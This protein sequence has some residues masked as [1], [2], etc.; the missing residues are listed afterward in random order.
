[1]L[2]RVLTESHPQGQR[3]LSESVWGRSSVQSIQSGCIICYLDS[4]SKVHWLTDWLKQDGRRHRSECDVKVSRGKMIINVFINC[5]T[6]VKIKQFI[7]LFSSGLFQMLSDWMDRTLTVKR[8]VNV[9]TALQALFHNV[10]W[11]EKALS[12]CT[13]SREDVVTQF[14]HY[15][16]RLHGLELLLGPLL[17]TWTGQW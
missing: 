14:D 11:R 6:W 10:S 5:L 15:D 3:S 8:V 2:R 7:N 17:W 12:G 1:M 13:V 16:N 9:S 4:Q